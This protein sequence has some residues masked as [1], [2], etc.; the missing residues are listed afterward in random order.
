[1]ICWYH[2]SRVKLNFFSSSFSVADFRYQISIW[3]CTYLGIRN[4]ISSGTE[5]VFSQTILRP[6]GMIFKSERLLGLVFP[7]PKIKASPCSSSQNPRTVT[8][9]VN[10]ANS[11]GFARLQTSPHWASEVVT[12]AWSSEESFRSGR[13]VESCCRA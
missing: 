5:S 7:F 13:K 11:N 6:V 4:L 8:S 9:T 3:L 2:P 12:A 10:G 1:M